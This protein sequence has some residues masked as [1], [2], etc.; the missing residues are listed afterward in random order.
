MAQTLSEQILSHAAGRVIHA[1]DFV[2]VKPDIVMSHDSLTPSIIQIMQ[3]NLEIAN[4]KNPQ[5]LVFVIDH[6]APPSTVNVANSQNVLRAFA[7]Q[8][9]V[10]YFDAG[11]GICHQVLIEEKIASPGKIVIGSDSHST[12]YGAVGAFGC[13][14]GSTDIALIWASGKTWLRVPHTLRVKIAG[15]FRPFVTAKDLALKLCKE[16]TIAGANYMAVEYHG[17]DWMRLDERQTISSMAIEMGAKAGIFP[18]MGIVAEHFDVPDWLFIDPTAEYRKTIHLDIQDLQPQI[19]IPHAVDQVVDLSE[20]TGLKIDLVFLGTCT[21]GRYEDLKIAAQILKNKRIANTLR[22]IITPAS[23]H[24]LARAASDD[25][26]STLV[27]AGAIITTPGC[28]MC[29]GRHL[30]TLGDNDVCLSTGNRNFRGRMGSANARIYL[31]SPA[32]AAATALHG[33]LADPRES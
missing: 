31:A 2:V 23:S 22:M 15:R 3:R 26:L 30:G 19:A 27:N 4:V 33:I 11:R 18:P 7:R 10:P 24:E 20:L 14:M 9:G 29:M 6:I 28:G 32:V 21:N 16:L 12:S 13:G 25:T 17:L 5:Q 1:G 8:Q